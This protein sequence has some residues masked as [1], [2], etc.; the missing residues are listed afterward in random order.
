MTVADSDRALKRERE[1]ER[2]CVCVTVTVCGRVCV[3]V[4]VCVCMCVCVFASVFGL[5]PR[6][7]HRQQEADESSRETLERM[8]EIG[9]QSKKGTMGPGQLSAFADRMELLG[10]AMGT[11]VR[12]K[13]PRA[14]AEVMAV[15]KRVPELHNEFS[16]DGCWPPECDARAGYQLL[17]SAYEHARTISMVRMRLVGERVQAGP[18]TLLIHL[19]S[20]PGATA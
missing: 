8:Y 18:Y 5:I 13:L 20:L 9:E 11:D 17:W 19:S 16:R 15:D 14:L 12:R 3:C 2:A 4:C 6:A 7:L 10:S 1:R